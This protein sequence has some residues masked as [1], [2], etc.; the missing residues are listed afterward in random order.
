MRQFEYFLNYG[1]KQK[2]RSH[3]ATGIYCYKK[4]DLN[5]HKD[6]EISGLGN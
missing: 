1:N 2:S 6:N 4:A 3:T 5:I